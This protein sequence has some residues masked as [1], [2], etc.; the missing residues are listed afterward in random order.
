MSNRFVKPCLI[1]G[2]K[3]YNKGVLCDKFP[4]HFLSTSTIEN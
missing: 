2:Y 4:T 1:I 3:N